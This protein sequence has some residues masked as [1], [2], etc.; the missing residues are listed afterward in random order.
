M[1]DTEITVDDVLN[2][3]VQEQ[4][5]KVKHHLDKRIQKYEKKYEGKDYVEVKKQCP[6]IQ[7]KCGLLISK[8]GMPIHLK[9]KKHAKRMNLVEKFKEKMPEQEVPFDKINEILQPTKYA[10]EWM[11]QKVTCECGSVISNAYR[12]THIR[13]KKHM[14]Y[15]QYKELE[16]RG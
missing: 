11:K 10:E 2:E 7:C 1:S 13:T 14:K 6:K 3:L 8:R 5:E 16:E 9:T 12:P 4:K 15:L